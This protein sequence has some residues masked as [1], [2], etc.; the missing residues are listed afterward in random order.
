MHLLNIPLVDDSVQQCKYAMDVAIVSGKIHTLQT[1]LG[2][3]KKT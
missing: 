3:D 1:T 2:H